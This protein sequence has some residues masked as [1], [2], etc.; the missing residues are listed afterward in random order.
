MF[1]ILSFQYKEGII[2]STLI[3]SHASIT[4]AGNSKIPAGDDSQCRWYFSP[5]MFCSVAQKQILKKLKSNIRRET[6]EKWLI[7]P[8]GQ[9]N[10]QL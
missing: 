3:I 8:K 9:E 2:C 10:K 1:P 7:M 5:L 6:I 4:S